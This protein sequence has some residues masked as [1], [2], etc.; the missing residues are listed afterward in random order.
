MQGEEG[1]FERFCVGSVTKIDGEL[2]IEE[3][4]THFN[5]LPPPAWTMTVLKLWGNFTNEITNIT[6]PT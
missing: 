5:F 4:S 2:L 1:A 3:I 6:Q